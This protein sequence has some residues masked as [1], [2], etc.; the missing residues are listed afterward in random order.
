MLEVFAGRQS[1]VVV[2]SSKHAQ[3]WGRFQAEEPK[4]PDDPS[5]EATAPDGTDQPPEACAGARL[6]SCL[7]G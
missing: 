6:G 7:A 4:A 2:A 3:I 1:S 5:G